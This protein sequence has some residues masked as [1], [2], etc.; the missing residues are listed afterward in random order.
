MFFKNSPKSH[1]SFNQFLYENLRSRTFKIAQSDHTGLDRTLNFQVD[2]DS[3]YCIFSSQI[4]T[5]F[6]KFETYCQ[7]LEITQSEQI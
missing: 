6:I 5:H 1:N 2:L 3:L 7:A 4:K